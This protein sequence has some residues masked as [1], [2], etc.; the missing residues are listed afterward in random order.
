MRTHDTYSN[1]T[2]TDVVIVGN[3]PIGATLSVLLAQRGWRVTVLE[4][5]ARPYR[6]PRATSFDGE[7]ARLLAATGIGPD[8]GRVTEPAN[9][10]QWQTPSGAALLDIA[11]ATAGPYGWPDANTMHQPA[12]EEL[13]A[14]RVAALAGITVLR[15]HE[16]VKIAD[17]GERVEVTA[18]TDDDATRVLS[19]RW[20]VGCDGA[21]SFV[22]DHLDVSVTDLGFSYE[23]LLCDVELHRPREF[24]PTN[25]QICDPAR[26]TT[27]VASGP[28][29][30]RW[31]FMRLPGES[32]AELNRDETAWRLLA[33]FGV[34]P[35]TA[36]LLRSTTYIFQARW[37]DQWRVGRVLLAG[38]AAHLMPPFAG[39]GMCSGIR[40]VVNLAW[41]LDLTLRGIAEESVL[42]SYTEERR[43]QAKEAI[44]AS[45]QLGRVICVTD[46]AAAAE[47]DATVLAN[48]R[49]K[50]A[51]R[52]EP[53]KALPGG[54]LH[55]RSGAEA[56]TAPAGAVVPQGRVARQGPA[57]LF[58]DVVGRGFVLLTTDDPHT[59]LDAERLSFLVGLGAHVVRLLP[60]G[61]ASGEHGSA[62]VIDVV[63]TDEVYGPYLARFG[64]TSLLVRPDYHVFGAASG[65]A[66]AASLVDDLRDR[67][68]AAVPAGAP[69]RTG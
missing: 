23:W 11:F 40:D 49:G 1:P 39:Q 54:L 29:R 61:H 55:R 59:L 63:D 15:G 34:T 7:T 12:L 62:D 20:V 48:R 43:A 16:V 38:D 3:G 60:P 56:A 66:G 67:L 9:G 25:V 6:L 5:R 14:A 47:R 44:L 26:P 30:R 17:D 2:D 10:Y 8:L 51:G 65:P 37:A 46:P 42:D 13:I 27:V 35:D 32:T 28:G 58:D 69:H 64:A 4:R 18:A 53:A 36:T 31:E 52:P 50:P 45:V 41:K 21:N 24:T 33:P 19:A 57:G 22:R 68:G